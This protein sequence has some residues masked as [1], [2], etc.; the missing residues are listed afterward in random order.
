MYLGISTTTF[1]KLRADGRVP[2]PRLCGDR[3]LWDRYELDLSFEALPV[4][5]DGAPATPARN[6]W[7]DV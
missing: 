5:N 1:D 6:S 3:K 2:K 7:E 4:D